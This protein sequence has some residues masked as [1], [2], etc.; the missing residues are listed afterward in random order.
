MDGFL[1]KLQSRV[2]VSTATDLQAEL[3]KGL[4]SGQDV[5]LD[6]SEVETFGTAAAQLL[7][8]VARSLQTGGRSLKFL[9]ISQAVQG[10]LETLGLTALA[11]H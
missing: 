5:I 3:M 7:A 4:A 10:D 2:D 11:E 1:I 6:C 8:A 9:N